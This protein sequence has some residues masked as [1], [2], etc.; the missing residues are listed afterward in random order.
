MH[1]TIDDKP[2]RSLRTTMLVAIPA[3]LLLVHCS[4]SLSFPGVGTGVGDGSVEVAADGSALPVNDASE[5][6]PVDAPPTDPTCRSTPGRGPNM[7]RVYAPNVP[8]FCIDVTE[9]TIAQYKSFLADQGKPDAPADCSSKNRAPKGGAYVLNLPDQTEPMRYVDWCDAATFCAWSG[10]RLCGKPGGGPA[11][12][13]EHDKAS[14]SQWYAACTQKDEKYPYGDN[15]VKG[16]CNDEQPTGDKVPECEKAPSAHPGCH[17]GIAALL[18]MTG[19]VKEWEDSCEGKKCRLR[20]GSCFNASDIATCDN[21][22]ERDREGGGGLSDV[23]FR[24]C[25]S[26]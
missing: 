14:D 19:N 17:G 4:L 11:V 26:P 24:C 7:V 22:E 18:A 20:G 3:T 21:N 15:H 2:W 1:E 10:K 13:K 12:F 25:T 5:E 16:T 23:G 6:P 9:V 8:S